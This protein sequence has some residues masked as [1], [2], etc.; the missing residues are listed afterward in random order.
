MVKSYDKD[1]II[2]FAN[3]PVVKGY[4][5]SAIYD[6]QKMQYH[7]IPNDL[8]TILQDS[9]AYNIGDLKIKFG[10]ENTA[11]IDEYI[12]FILDQSLG[13]ILN[14]SD[15]DSFLDISLQWDYPG[16]ISNAIIDIG[17]WSKKHLKRVVMEL[18]DIGCLHVQ[19]RSY[20]NADIN[21]WNSILD[22]FSNTRITSIDLVGKY[23]KTMDEQSLEKCL[24][25][26][27]RVISFLLHSSPGNTLQSC[28][29]KRVYFFQQ[30]ILNEKSCG[31]I[32]SQYFNVNVQLFT[33]SQSFNS[34]LNKKIAID[35]NG[36]IKNCPSM[37][38][39]LGEIE[40]S[41]L[42]E[43]VATKAFDELR[44]FKK[45]DISVCK[46]CEFRYMCTDCR[47]YLS[48]PT[49]MYSKPLKCGYDP[50]TAEWKNWTKQ[51]NVINAI[52]FY[53]L[54]QLE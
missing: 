25:N 22:F 54:K 47:A 12:E 39:D 33:E 21:Y 15:I 49:D 16:N 1:H 24:N 41:S 51:S 2:L 7:L 17:E 18:S 8:Y 37:K 32:C 52:E 10:I 20:E 3:C 27:P 35:R 29:L 9:K 26:N 36:K 38:V 43:T 23:D 11:T 31:S 40:S 46:D 4:R 53:G 6:L 34:C 44:N 30:N 13:H 28:I 14:F 45:D 5:R 48:I 19:I 42:A 50:Y